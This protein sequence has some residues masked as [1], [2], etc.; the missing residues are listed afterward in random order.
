MAVSDAD[1][2]NSSDEVEI[3]SSLV[4]P[5]P[6]HVSLV[7]QQRLLVHS[8]DVGH[9]VLTPYRTD[10]L[11]RRSLSITLQVSQSINIRLIMA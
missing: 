3:S 4:V 5:Q 8:Q 1:C 6:L 10:P 11:V 9:Q 7:H 2:N